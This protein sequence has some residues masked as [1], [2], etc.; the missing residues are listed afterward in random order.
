MFP[1]NAILANHY[2]YYLYDLEKAV[3]HYEIFEN[4][5]NQLECLINK[6]GHFYFLERINGYFDDYI[7]A[8][9]QA[10]NRENAFDIINEKKKKCGSETEA[11]TNQ[12]LI[13]I[14]KSVSGK[15]VMQY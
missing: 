4:K 7:I 8:L 12:N 10:G 15:Q 11:I 14:K 6:Y 2:H 3:F 1:L 5:K 9:V 13:I